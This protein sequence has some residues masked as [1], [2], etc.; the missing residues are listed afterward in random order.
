MTQPS[1]IELIEDYCAKADI[2]PTTLGVRVLGNSRFYDRLK[3]KLG[4]LEEDEAK[5]RAYMAA[6]PPEKSQVSQ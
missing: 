3:R 6:H 1:L 4:K 5:V 2:E